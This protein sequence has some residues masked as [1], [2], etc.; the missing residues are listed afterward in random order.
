M[1]RTEAM[2]EFIVTC[3]M[4][5]MWGVQP[6]P[7]PLYR[8]TNERLRRLDPYMQQAEYNTDVP[9]WVLLGI[10]HRESRGRQSAVGDGGQAQG[11]AQTWCFWMD[12]LHEQYHCDRLY[13]PGYSIYVATQVLLHLRDRWET[14]WPET[15][16]LYHL[17]PRGI[18]L[19]SP[20]PYLHHVRAYGTYYARRYRARRRLGWT[21]Y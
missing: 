5:T 9:P 20:H 8:E 19:E 2:L 15:I 12:A 3:T 17:G 13:H 21:G 10:I 14:T 6:T 18:G 7:Q 4:W 1:T 11:L 16:M